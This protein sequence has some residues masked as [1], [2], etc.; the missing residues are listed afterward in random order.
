MYAEKEPHIFLVENEPEYVNG[1]Y[2]SDESEQF[3][4][5]F[6]TI[7]EAREIFTKYCE[8]LNGNNNRS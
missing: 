1:W 5:P 7:E 8:D 3:N 6:N 2:F 4:G